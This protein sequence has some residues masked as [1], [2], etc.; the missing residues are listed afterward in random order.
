ML[1]VLILF[2]IRFFHTSLADQIYAFLRRN[3]RLG[4]FNRPLTSIEL[5][6]KFDSRP[7]LFHKIIA[8]ENHSL[9]QLL[10]A[11]RNSLNLCPRGHDF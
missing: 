2:T 10:P 1:I 8:D 11:R 7:T 9:S 6:E 4:V 5:L 3:I